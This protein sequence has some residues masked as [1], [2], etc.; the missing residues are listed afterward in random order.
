M[1]LFILNAI[2]LNMITE[3]PAVINVDEIEV[4]NVKQIIDDASHHQMNVISAVGHQDTAAL[5]SNML[6][7]NIAFNRMDVFLEKGDFCLVAQYSGPRLPEGA[8]ELPKGASI[9]WLY[10]SIVI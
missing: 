7:R 2:S 5:I 9:K 10:M 3:F 8:N 4:E 1:N 6:E